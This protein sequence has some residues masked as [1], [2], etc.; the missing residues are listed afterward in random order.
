[1]NIDSIKIFV[2]DFDGV[3]TDNTVYVSSEAGTEFVKCSRADGL[4]FDAV[5]KIDVKTI[6]LSSETNRVVQNRADKLKIQAYTASE[7]KVD[8]LIEILQQ[9]SLDFD[10]VFYVGNDLNDLD[11]IMKCKYSACPS[12]SHRL[13]KEKV[14]YV[15]E[16]R[17]GE[18]VFREILEEIFK[19]DI[20]SILY[21]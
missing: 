13:I 7:N 1:M 2:L 14:T 5:R 20:H 11:V 19:L 12:D 17:G 21:K 16:S 18:G 4:G 15:L 8:S 6:I 3:L 9:F 10:D